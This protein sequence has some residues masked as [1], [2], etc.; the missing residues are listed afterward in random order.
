MSDV[1][2][3]I[4]ATYLEL[5]K[6]LKVPFTPIE[7]STLNAKFGIAENETI[8]DGVYPE[9]Q[10]IAIG[11]GGHRGRITTGGG[12]VVDVI[13]HGIAHAVLYEQ[14]PF[15][16]RE[17][18]NDLSANERLKYG[19]RHLVNKDGINYFAYYLK[20]L[21]FTS[22]YPVIKEI[23]ISDGNVTSAEYAPGIQ[24]LSAL[25]PEYSNNAV[26]TSSGKHLSVEST[27]TMELTANDIA[28][29]INAVDISY[30]DISYAIISE[31]ATV[32]AV[33]TDITTDL[34]GVNATYKEAVAAQ[35]ANHIP[36]NIVLQFAT[37]GIT[38]HYTLGHVAPY[39]Q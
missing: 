24:Q 38:H 12:T 21:D 29:I 15:I 20:R 34:G 33:P 22:T 32:T 39:V 11:R 35:I 8:A 18:D 36:T 30:G 26:N 9:L 3:T 14:I 31:I 4:Y 27:L 1:T 19:M 23:T 10:Y 2:K 5:M 13:P 28:E 25:K 7:Y 16:M 37:E 17:V 6:E